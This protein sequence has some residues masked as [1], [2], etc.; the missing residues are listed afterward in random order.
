MAARDVLL[1]RPEGRVGWLAICEAIA[2]VVS[3][4]AVWIVIV[5]IEYCTQLEHCE[6]YCS[7]SAETEVYRVGQKMT[8]HIFVTTSSN[9]HQ[10][11]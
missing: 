11:W 9:L 4:L 6:P 2:E 5:R 7:Y 8:Q 10:I 1:G 3:R